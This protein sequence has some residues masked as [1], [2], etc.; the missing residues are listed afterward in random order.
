MNNYIN[1][2]G[3]QIELS[4]ET[5]A[6]LKCK[7]GIKDKLTYEDIAEKLFLEKKSAVININHG[8]CI[9]YYT[10]NNSQIEYYP[11]LLSVTGAQLESILALNKLANVAKYLNG[12]WLPDWEN[13]KEKYYISS[14]KMHNGLNIDSIE[15]VKS[16]DVYFKS[17]K[18][19][20]Q[21][22]EILGEKE[23]K[24]ALTLNH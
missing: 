7:L 16:S 1:I 8:K 9:G 23:I 2:D 18:L 17:E 19:A 21:A 15:G 10:I 5:V 24:K 3:K 13:I 20:R 11:Q 12:D 4:E 14:S 6:E 22:I